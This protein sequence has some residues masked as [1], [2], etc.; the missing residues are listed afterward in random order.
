MKKFKKPGKLI[1]LDFNSEMIAFAKNLFESSLKDGIPSDVGI[2]S[3]F[4]QEDCTNMKSIEDCSID[5]VRCDI[6]LM[7]V[8]HDKALREIKRVL[9]SGGLF[10]ALEGGGGG[11]FFCSDTYVDKIYHSVLP[12]PPV[13]G[14]LGVQLWFLL[15]T[16]GFTCCQVFSKSLVNIDP[17]DQDPGWVKLKGLSEMLVTRGVLSR[18]EVDEYIRRYIR[19]CE[20]KEIFITSFLFLHKAIKA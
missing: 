11:K 6:T 13:D 18:D 14:G 5:V 3:Q 15:P 1:G 7:H 12:P 19:A 9:K 16:L 17:S 20:E 2:E 4:L 10:L 8:D